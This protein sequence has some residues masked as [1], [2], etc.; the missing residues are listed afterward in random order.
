MYKTLKITEDFLYDHGACYGG[1]AEFNKLFPNGVVISNSQ[2]EMI[3]LLLEYEGEFS[4][5]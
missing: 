4:Y 2:E 5:L 3:D 1:I